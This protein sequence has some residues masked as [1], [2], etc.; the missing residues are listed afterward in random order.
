MEAGH[1]LA[2]LLGVL[3]GIGGCHFVTWYYARKIAALVPGG[4]KAWDDYDK[5]VDHASPTGRTVTA[6]GDGAA[7]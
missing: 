1:F 3:F 6:G 2:L 4:I 7:S 5:V